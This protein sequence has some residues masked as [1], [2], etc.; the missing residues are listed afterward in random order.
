MWLQ[1]V[2]PDPWADPESRSTVGFCNLHHRSS[3]IQNWGDSTFSDPPRG[4]GNRSQMALRDRCAMAE[5]AG[6]PSV[7]WNLSRD[8]G[9]LRLAWD[10]G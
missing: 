2:H 6:A 10:I 9:L 4:L 5:D 7:L 3:R 8:V 1:H